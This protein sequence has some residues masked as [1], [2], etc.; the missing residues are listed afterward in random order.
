MVW[1]GRPFSSI[2]KK[3]VRTRRFDEVDEAP[4]D[5]VVL[6]ALDR[7]QHALD[8]GP[9]ARFRLGALVGAARIEAGVEQ[10][11]DLARDGAVAGERRGEVVLAEGEADLAQVAPEG[12]HHGDVAP[13]ELGL[14]HELVEGVRFGKPAEE[15]QDRRLDRAFDG[16][17]V[18]RA[19]GGAL[20]RHVVEPDPAGILAARRVDPIGALVDDLEAEVL[21]QR[22]AFG[23]RQRGAAREDLEVDARVGIAVAAVEVDGPRALVREALEDRDV[24]DRLLGREGFAIGGR[25]GA[26]VARRERPRLRAAD[27]LGKCC[28]Q[29][30]GPGAHDRGNA[31]LELLLRDLRRR[32]LVA[33]DDVVGAGERP[34]GVARI[35][36]RHAALVGAGEVLADAPAHRRV[37]AVLRHEDEHRDEAVELVR[38]RERPDARPLGQVHDLDREAVERLLVDLEQLVARIVLEHVEERAAGVAR[39]VEAGARRHLGDLV[40]QIRHLVE[41]ARI[42]VGGEQA[43]DPQL[44]LQAPFGR[45]QL[46]ADVVEM[47]AAVH[48][49]L[50]VRLGA[51]ERLRAGQEGADLR[52]HG[53]ELAAAPQHLHGGVAQQAEAGCLDRIG[54]GVALGRRYSRMPRKVKLSSASQSRKATASETSSAGS[55]GGLAR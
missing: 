53:D 36:R 46:D 40:A 39:R 49:R 33:A 11:D 13:A 23:Q 31:G 7:L 32:A 25:E 35:G 14:E 29:R 54:G 42:G 38:P 24:G 50:D 8:L 34:L 21:E 3:L 27:R 41:R 19:A 28:R 18:E 22:H 45:E 5:A 17:D 9:D 30:V 1:R 4:Q 47:D 51:D 52:A 15:R 43:D 48:A 26:G 10:L 6:Q 55:G 12:A 37:V 20:E 44:A 2:W 16:A